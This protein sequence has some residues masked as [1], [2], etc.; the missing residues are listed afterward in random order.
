MPAYFGKTRRRL[1]AVDFFCGAGGLSYGMQEAGIRI[2]AGLDIDPNCRYPFETN[3]GARFYERDVEGLN[4]EFVGSLFPDDC[5]R[6]LAGCAPC[7]PFSPYM[8]GNSRKEERSDGRWR[9]LG[10]FGEAVSC[11]RPEIVTMENVPGIRNHRVFDDFL[12]LLDDLEYKVFHDIVKCEQYGV[13]QTRRRL[14]LL[15]SKLGEI[16]L[17]PGTH[18]R[19]E[20]ETVESWIRGMEPLDAGSTAGADPLHKSSGLSDRNLERIR[21]SSPGGTWRDW[22]R[23]LRAPCHAKPGG[24]TYGNVYGRMA[25]DKPAPTITTQFHGFGSGRFGHPEDDRAISLREG[26]ILQTFPK[27][28]A[29]VP[30]GD[31]VM[32]KPIARM[33]GNAVPVKI[34]EAIGQS[35]ISHA[36]NVYG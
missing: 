10:K 7:Q 36:V 4:V 1:V 22:K 26:A 17:A 2:A 16:S 34:G 12:A 32:I 19:D 24:S 6:I 30:P 21:A 31:P 23:D 18:D 35:I 33:I 3:V 15:A 11:I 27:R 25:W 28:Y 5:I 14:V 29:F 20:H 13:P 8:N 9:L